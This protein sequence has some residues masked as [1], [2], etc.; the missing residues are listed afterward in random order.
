MHKV[1]HKGGVFQC[2][3]CSNVVHGIGVL[4]DCSDVN[5]AHRNLKVSQKNCRSLAKVEGQEVKSSIHNY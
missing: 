3:H 1:S 4:Q 5:V 2:Y